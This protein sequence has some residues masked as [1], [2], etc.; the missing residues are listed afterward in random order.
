MSTIVKAENISIHYNF[1][2]PS[3][4]GFRVRFK[5][6]LSGQSAV[7]ESRQIKALDDVSFSI[8]E[9]ERVAFIGS[10][11]SGKTTLLRVVGGILKPT[12]G[13]LDLSGRVNAVFDPGLGMDPEASG[14]ENI[15]IRL[16][17]GEVDPSR[18]S[19]KAKEIAEFSDLG[20][21]LDRPLKTYSSGMAVRLSFAIA[22]AIEPEIMVMDEWLSA[23]DV[24][25]VERA[26]GKMRSLVNSSRAL[27][28]A[29]HSQDIVENW[30]TRAVW[31]DQGKIIA[32][33][34][35]SEIWEEYSCSSAI[36]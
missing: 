23:G 15:L 1:I 32:D 36:E 17:L 18:I 14:Y 27:L 21:A 26:L 13:H 6:L 29:S 20:A 2:H 33:G 8:S 3:D 25:F 4:T 34:A 11:G 12:R 19:D 31:L 7:D 16:M 22:T 9:G 35:P 10:N 28:I 30:C 5:N 24:R